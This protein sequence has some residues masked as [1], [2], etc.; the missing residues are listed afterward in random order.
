MTALAKGRKS[1]W[2]RRADGSQEPFS[3]V[4]HQ[5]GNGTKILALEYEVEVQTPSGPR[6]LAFRISEDQPAFA[7][8]MALLDEAESLRKEL[9]ALQKEMEGV[10][11]LQAEARLKAHK[12]QKA[13]TSP[14]E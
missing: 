4:E 6:R 2:A 3:L 1:G 9:K 8:T 5:V 10:K 7:P 11:L 12:E 14:G 13:S